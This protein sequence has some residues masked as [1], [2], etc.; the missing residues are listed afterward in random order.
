MEVCLLLLLCQY[1][2]F[3]EE[4]R[5]LLAAYEHNAIRK[6]AEESLEEGP[7][8]GGVAPQQVRRGTRSVALAGPDKCEQGHHVSCCL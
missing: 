6:R 8:G 4:A 5:E 2:L 1:E 7:E 3:G